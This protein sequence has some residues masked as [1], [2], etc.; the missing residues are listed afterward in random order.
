MKEVRYEL[1]R[2]CVLAL[3]TGR[4]ATR[5]SWG[6]LPQVEGLAR[7]QAVCSGEAREAAELRAGLSTDGRPAVPAGT[8]SRSLPETNS[9]D[10]QGPGPLHLT[11]ARVPQNL[12]ISNTQ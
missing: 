9:H 11:P 6:E 12:N 10:N 5:V 7:N 1:D 2:I 8:G 3:N 4:P